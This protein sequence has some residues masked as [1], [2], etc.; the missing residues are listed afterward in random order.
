MKKRLIILGNIVIILTIIIVSALNYREL[1]AKHIQSFEYYLANVTAYFDRALSHNLT[2]LSQTDDF[3]S[4]AGADEAKRTNP[5]NNTKQIISEDNYVTQDLLEQTIDETIETFNVLASDLRITVM[6][7]TGKVLIDSSFA[8]DELNNHRARPEVWGVIS[9]EETHSNVRFS[10]TESVERL[11]FSA[12]SKHDNMIVRAAVLMDTLID[13]GSTI[14]QYALIIGIIILAAFN[15]IMSL[16]FRKQDKHQ[17]D[18]VQTLAKIEAGDLS[19]RMEEDRYTFADYR[20]FS[21]NFNL[22][23][24]NFEQ[25]FLEM[26]AGRA[27]LDA[28]V[29]SLMEPLVVVNRDLQIVFA[30]K[31]AKTL[32]NRDI[33]PEINP[34][35]FVLLTHDDKLDDLCEQVF[36]NGKSVRGEFK[37]QVTGRYN[38]FQVMISPVDADHVVVL[39][40]DISYEYEARKLRS[41]FVA[42]VTHELKTPLTSIRGFVETLRNRNNTTP[43]QA[44]NFLEIIDVE[45]ARL[46]RLINDILRLSD[47]ERLN[48][49]SELE[50]FDLVELLDECLVQLDDQASEKQINLIPKDEP[51]FLP[52]KAN[53]D[54]IKQ[55]LLNLLENA[56][57]YHR[58]RGNVWIKL[59]RQ[60][61]FVTIKVKDDGYGFDE[62]SAKR[63]FERFYRVDKSRSRMLGGTGLGLSIVKHIALLYDGEASVKSTPNKGSTFKVILKI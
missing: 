18:L 40:N 53:R 56:I 63:V 23:V 48:N 34:Y 13:A 25:S 46:E 52:V 4:I 26:Q 15:V 17:A 3:L 62:Q 31:Y 2:K 37:L 5:D 27:W 44:N 41:S 28:M 42:N 32:F 21:E 54:R 22:T 6:D 1:R 35:P 33:D 30:N 7:E 29:N 14:K 10:N 47:I 60:G 39:F 20:K 51:T 45:A 16:L 19:A 59:E 24:A 58:M 61:K 49:D 57:K 8:G 9:G 36:A 38:A 11:Y 43:E 50:D 55:V 12:R